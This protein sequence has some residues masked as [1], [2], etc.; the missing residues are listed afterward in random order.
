MKI[1][2][3][4]DWHI[5]KRLERFSRF[6]EQEAVLAEI[7]EITAAEDPDLVLVAGDL[8]DTF[9]PGSDAQ[10]LLY[11]TLRDLGEVGR[12]GSRR[13]VPVRAVVAI[14]GNHDSPDRV[15]APEVLA[16]TH[17]IVLAGY[18]GDVIV[19]FSAGAVTARPLDPGLFELRLDRPGLRDVPIRILSVPYAN[20]VRLR[21]SLA[22]GPDGEAAGEADGGAGDEAADGDEDAAL[23]AV[24]ADVWR[25][26]AA[27]HLTGEGVNLMV[28]HL[29]FAVDP[30]APGEEPEGERPI[31][32]IGGAPAISTAIVPEA[33]QYVACGHLHRAHPLAG[34]VAL[35]YSGSPLGYSFAEAEQEKSVTIIEVEPRG[36]LG[37]EPTVERRALTAG[38]PLLRYHAASVEDALVWLGEHPDALVELAISLPD[39][40]SGSDRRR[41][42]DAHDGI[43]TIVPLAAG[44]ASGDGGE[45]ARIDPTGDIRDLFSRYFVSRTGSSP[46]QA[47]TALFEEVLAGAGGEAGTAVEG[48]GTVRGAGGEAAAAVEDLPT[49]PAA[50][51]PAITD[52]E[53]LP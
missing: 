29:M 14:A 5:G 37:A 13:G 49:G 42:H 52:G 40:L 36:S 3:T 11:R 25:D 53:D 38:R 39:Y 15:I 26:L 8:F 27:R 50:T 23:Q 6:A 43:V 35:H 19:P 46:D 51:G 48:D 45:G 20:E 10:E 16:R 32:H 33:F 44:A 24:L 1:L 30:A 12:D 41:L 4:A 47:L 22:L 17:G 21:R 2:H 28:A 9:N 31:A 34:P 18:P 7:V